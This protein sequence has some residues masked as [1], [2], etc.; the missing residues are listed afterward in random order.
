MVGVPGQ[1]D[2]SICSCLR[3]ALYGNTTRFSSI[4]VRGYN[5][6]QHLM[7][8]ANQRIRNTWKEGTHEKMLA[9]ATKVLVLLLVLSIFMV[10]FAVP[11]PP[12][13]V[14]AQTMTGRGFDQYGGWKGLQGH[15]TTGHWTVELIGDRYWF[16]TPENVVLVSP[17]QH[18][19]SSLNESFGRQASGTFNQTYL[20]GF[21]P[22]MTA[23][24]KPE[25]INEVKAI[26]SQF[27][28]GFTKS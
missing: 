18:G 6:M 19:K 27:G 25:S 4:R 5:L 7:V 24:L 10:G 28:Q 20:D 12:S 2:E 21:I 26:M 9:I 15:N 14:T 8:D 1:H 11:L 13:S 17:R 22:R 16:V 3:R 23:L